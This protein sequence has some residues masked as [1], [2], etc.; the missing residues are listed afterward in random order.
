MRK[1]KYRGAKDKL[2]LKKVSA[3]FRIVRWVNIQ[4]SKTSVIFFVLVR[5]TTLAGSA[6]LEILSSEAQLTVSPP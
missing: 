3:Y 6:K 2:C 4:P 1:K 5:I